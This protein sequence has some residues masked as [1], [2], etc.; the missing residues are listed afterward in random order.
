MLGLVAPSLARKSVWL[1]AG[2]DGLSVAYGMINMMKMRAVAIS[3][4]ALRFVC[5]A[6]RRNMHAWLVGKSSVF[7]ELK[8]TIQ[9]DDMGGL[10]VLGYKS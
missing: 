8:K 5:R 3:T 9:E 7:G 6:S 10:G 2:D 4:V 1:S